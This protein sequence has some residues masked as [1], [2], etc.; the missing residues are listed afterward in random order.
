M[1]RRNKVTKLVQYLASHKVEA[2]ILYTHLPFYHLLSDSLMLVP[3]GDGNEQLC[4][5]ARL[6]ATY[7]TGNVAQRQGRHYTGKHI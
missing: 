5:V 2:S 1:T 4:L 3:Q 7:Q 6:Q